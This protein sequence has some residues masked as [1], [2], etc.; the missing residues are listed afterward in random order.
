MNHD[1]LLRIVKILHAMKVKSS[2]HQMRDPGLTFKFSFFLLFQLDRIVQRSN[3]TLSSPV[4]YLPD[5]VY[6]HGY[7]VWLLVDAEF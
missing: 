7:F 3:V 1:Y 4:G 2:K 5:L 6:L